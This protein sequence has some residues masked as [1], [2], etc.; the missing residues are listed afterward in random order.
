MIKFWT[1]LGFFI[2][3]IFLVWGYTSSRGTETQKQ[4]L[5]SICFG[6]D[7]PETPENHQERDIR[8]F[9]D[10][11]KISPKYLDKAEGILGMSWTHF[12]TMLFL[13]FFSVA[14]VTA[15]V[16][17]HRRTKQLLNQLL[18]EKEHGTDS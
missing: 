3:L 15:L 4:G 17:R 2:L 9:R 16:I 8:W 5:T 14:A 12:F 1:K 18:Q 10:E 13:V 7:K 11:M 6:Q